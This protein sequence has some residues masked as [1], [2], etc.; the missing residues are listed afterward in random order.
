MGRKV[1]QNLEGSLN[2]R[3]RAEGLRKSSQLEFTGPRKCQR[4]ER[5]PENRRGSVEGPALGISKVVSQPIRETS[6]QSWGTVVFLQVRKESL[7]I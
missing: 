6:T 1:K 7:L 5:C 2:W 3:E 4:E